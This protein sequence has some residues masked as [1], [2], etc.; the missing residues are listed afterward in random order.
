MRHLEETV[1]GVCGPCCVVCG[2]LA[3]Q[4]GVNCER[5]EEWIKS[6]VGWRSWTVFLVFF[7][8]WLY[9]LMLIHAETFRFGVLFL[10]VFLFAQTP[11]V[12]SDIR[13]S[14]WRRACLSFIGLRHLQEYE[15]FASAPECE[16]FA[17]TFA[18]IPILLMVGILAAEGLDEAIMGEQEN[19]VGIVLF[20][21]LILI[22]AGGAASSTYK[23]VDAT[24]ARTVQ[25]G[26]IVERLAHHL[27]GHIDGGLARLGAY[28]THGLDALALTVVMSGIGTKESYPVLIKWLGSMWLICGVFPALIAP[29]PMPTFRPAIPTQGWLWFV[30]RSVTSIIMLAFPP[31]QYMPM[32]NRRSQKIWAVFALVRAALLFA[33]GSIWP[34]SQIPVSDF[35]CSMWQLTISIV[36]RVGIV[37]GETEKCPI[38]GSYRFDYMIYVGASATVLMALS[39]LCGRSTEKRRTERLQRSSRTATLL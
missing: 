4:C 39:R 24:T 33:T 28:V 31:T 38:L 5:D 27:G 3:Y 11:F 36:G 22:T 7:N 2:L 23:C 1:S 18:R 17:D 6:K 13:D 32:L 12:I 10:V 35:W 21:V 29:P 8:E 37:L 9:L 15:G 30:H 16:L 34:P 19:I 25:S 26:D 20:A 14:S